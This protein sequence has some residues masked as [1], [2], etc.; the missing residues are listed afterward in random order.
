MIRAKETMSMMMILSVIG[1]YL[2]VSG[3]ILIALAKAAGRNTPPPPERE[4]GDTH[5]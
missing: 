5:E 4:T 1:G 2:A 3:V